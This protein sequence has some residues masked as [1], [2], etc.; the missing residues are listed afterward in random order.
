MNEE[1]FQKGRAIEFVKIYVDKLDLDLSGLTVATECASNAYGYTAVLAAAAGA[2]VLAVGKDSS[3]GSFAENS[4]KTIAVLKQLG[5]EDRVA[6]FKD[7]I[8]PEQLIKT[9]IVTNSGCVRPITKQKIEALSDQAVICLMWETWEL[10]DGEVDIEACQ[11]KNI[12]V[13]GTDEHFH[14]CDMFTYPGM[15]CFKLL[16]E[17]GL[18]VGNNEFVLLGGGLTGRLIAETLRLNNITFD[19]YHNDDKLRADA[20]GNYSDLRNILE[21][22]RLDAVICAEHSYHE[23]LVG[24]KQILNFPEIKEKFKYAKWAHISG[25]IDADDLKASGLIYAPERIMPP[26][27]MSY[28]TINLGWEPVLI[29]NSAGLKVGEIAARSRTN[30][31]TPEDAIKATVDFGIG[32]DFEGGFMNYGK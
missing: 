10:R 26:G 31:G 20:Q 22:K 1:E 8:P 9:D 3:Y 29:L 4:A 12:P 23:E 18:E 5:I 24:A 16:F 19:W 28:E 6:F 13:I 27:Y 14:L 2:Q 17:M 32:Q 7:E 15:L 21:R 25:N 11:K 30:G